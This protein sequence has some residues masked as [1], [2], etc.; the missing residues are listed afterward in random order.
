M[1]TSKPTVLHILNYSLPYI[2]GYCS[3][4]HY[5]LTALQ[6]A[7]HRVTALTS[8]RHT[9][10]FPDCAGEE[11]IDGIHY[12]R[13]AKAP[14]IWNPLLRARAFMRTL[15]LQ[16][17][18]TA[19]KVNPDI[20]HAH[21]P[22]LCGIPACRAARRLGIPFVY[23]VRALWE[24]A[25]VDQGTMDRWS[26]RY[27]LSRYAETGLFRRADAVV[28][29]CAPLAREIDTRTGGTSMVVIAPNGVD[30]SVFQ[31]RPRNREL[32]ISTGVKNSTVVGYIGTFFRFEGLDDLVR[33]WDTIV[34]DEPGARLVLVGEGEVSQTLADLR[35]R[36]ARPDSIILTGR[37]PHK[38]VLDYYSIMDIMVYPR[39]SVRLTELVTPLKPLEA[40][41]MEKAVAG[42]D[43]GG[44]RE[45]I[46]HGHTGMLFPP[47]S[48]SGIAE[49]VRE[50]I[51]NE[52][53]RT[54]LAAAARNH[55]ESERTWDAIT[56]RYTA[57]YHSLSGMDGRPEDGNKPQRG[58]QT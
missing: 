13:T 14:R 8:P 16:I 24:D 17:E 56:A 54:R 1:N 12:M 35:A 49:A 18:R 30:T 40:M 23:E 4:S 47:E 43:V 50:L 15:Q 28:T 5:I 52:P 3:R 27:H 36:S 37:V 6:R 22:S 57:L 29:L 10:M 25:A 20:I 19:G 48:T 11:Q 44:L 41:A 33:G 58:Q 46:D 7:G 34:A 45:L 51:R 21:S 38:K 53:L 26:W 39:K 31:P 2:S 55:V 32:A 42:S 9:D